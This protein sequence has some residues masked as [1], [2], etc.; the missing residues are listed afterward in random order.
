MPTAIIWTA[1]MG[2]GMAGAAKGYSMGSVATQECAKTG[3]AAM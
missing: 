1:E 2:R 3:P